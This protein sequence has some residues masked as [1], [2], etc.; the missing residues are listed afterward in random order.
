MIKMAV[1]K[2]RIEKDV[3]KLLKESGFD[4]KP[5]ENKGRELKIIKTKDDMEFVFVKPK[6]VVRFI[7]KGIVD[8]GVVGNDTLQEYDSSEYSELLDLNV[9]KCFFALASYP[10]YK[11]KKYNTKKKIATKYPKI[12]S[13]YFK[14]KK[15]D[16]EI[17]KMEGSVELGPIVGMADAIVD[18][19]ETGSTLK[20]NGLVVF[21]KISK[22]STRLITNKNSLKNKNVEIS[23][24]VDKLSKQIERREIYTEEN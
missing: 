2:G 6:D 22:V 4:V 24:I 19:V 17:I 14:E 12:A 9:G 11:N 8:I 15:E 21:D 7:Q 20:S 13:K 23:K 18:I 1:T 16:V 10:E 3:C 5:I